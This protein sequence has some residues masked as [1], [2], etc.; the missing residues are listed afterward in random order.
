MKKLLFIAGSFLIL[1]CVGDSDPSPSSKC[2]TAGNGCSK[3]NKADC[4]ARGSCEWI[5]NKG[6]QCR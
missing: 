5:V 3:Y 2:G 4:Q 6:C 1:N